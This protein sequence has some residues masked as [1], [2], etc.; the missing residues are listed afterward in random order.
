MSTL[1]YAGNFYELGFDHHPSAPR[2]AVW[3]DRI[4]IEEKAEILAYLRAG[5]MFVFSPG[6]DRDFFDQ[7]RLADTRSLVTDGVYIWPAYFAYYV[8][9]YDIGI[10]EDFEAHMRA[11]NWTPPDG[12]DI[13]RLK[14]PSIG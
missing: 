6:V 1:R 14:L 3:R 12:V 8:D 9:N 11:C 2:I 13:N 10:P 4:A 5:V 7:S